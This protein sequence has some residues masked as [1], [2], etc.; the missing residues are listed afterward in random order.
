MSAVNL[1]GWRRVD[2]LR[3]LLL[4]LP[5]DF[6]PDVVFGVDGY[7]RLDVQVRFA[8]VH[9][10]IRYQRLGLCAK[11]RET[12]CRVAGQTRL[13]DRAAAEQQNALLG[14]GPRPINDQLEDCF[15]ILG[16]AAQTDIFNDTG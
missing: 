7:P 10:P 5:N 13:S 16:R 4:F 3:R 15:S 9:R 12:Q 2:E 6:E 1:K 11:I 8:A 14:F